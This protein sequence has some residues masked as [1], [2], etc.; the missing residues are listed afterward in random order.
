MKRK[1]I[2]LA[3]SAA[4]CSA[5]LLTG[6]GGDSGNQSNAPTTPANNSSS[7]APPVSSAQETNYTDGKGDLDKYHVEILGART[8]PD[9][10]GGTDALIKVRFTNVSDDDPASFALKLKMSVFQD[11]IG[12]NTGFPKVN[13]YESG[14]QYKEIKKGASLDIEIPVKLSDEST[15][16]EVEIAPH[17]ST[18]KEKV[19]QILEFV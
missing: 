19:T 11:G 13:D 17:F 14:D 16:M 5:A 18:K 8:S 12:L 15:P 2:V 4:M 6:C 9:S 7:S 10:L 1:L 3:L